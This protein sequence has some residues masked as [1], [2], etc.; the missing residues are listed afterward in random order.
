MII[1]PFLEHLPVDPRRNLP[2]PT[3]NQYET[4]HDFTAI[5]GQKVA[6]LARERACGICA[7]PL[8]YWLA[9]IGGPLSYQSRQYVDPPMHPACAE[10]SLTA[11]PHITIGRAR[12]ATGNHLMADATTPE[13]FQLDKPDTWVMGITRSYTTTNH[14]AQG[15]GF[16]TLFRAAPFKSAKAFGYDDEG[17]L[18]P[19]ALPAP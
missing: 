12:R 7:K 6:D 11:C 2:I 9:F 8:D 17:N 1:P 19:R 18:T 3:I 5:N 10:F 16:T 4:G 15:G 13:G 14:P